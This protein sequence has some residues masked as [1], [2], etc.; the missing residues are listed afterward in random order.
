[1][2]NRAKRIAA[3]LLAA[4][5]IMLCACSGQK[6]EGNPADVSGL[7]VNG[8]YSAE[9]ANVHYKGDYK[10]MDGKRN[11]RA[12]CFTGGFLLHRIRR[13]LR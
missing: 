8:G 5:T 11:L 12:G 4:I 7:P 13:F 9:L 2:S 3:L 1:M 6:S 10:Q